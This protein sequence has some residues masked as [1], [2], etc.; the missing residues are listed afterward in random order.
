[1]AFDT[2]EEGQE[3]SAPIELYTFTIGAVISRWTSAEDDITEAADVFTAIPISRGTLK[4]GGPDTRKENLIITVP[5]DN[6]VATQYINSV[7]GTTAT[8]KIERVQR[9]D[10]P[11]FTVVTIFNGSVSSVAFTKAGREAKIRIVPLVTAQSKPVPNVTYQGLCNRVLYDDFC[12]VDD[13]D[14]AFRLSTA[15]VTAVSGNTIT[16]TGADLNGD[17]YYTGGFV[18]ASG[19]SDRRLILDQTGTLLTLLLPF[20]TSPL[21]TNVTV[22]AGCDHAVST[23]KT[24]FN[25][26]VN[27]GGFAWVPTKNVFATG[28]R[29]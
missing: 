24:K 5:G 10:G 26:V 8:L 16:V 29:I 21:L 28:I 12:Q 3:T 11:T 13:T 9:S 19:A 23:C 17:G 2:Y 27:F 15:A 18:E 1:M 25:N 22:F 20:S 4:G 7:P 14:V 6:A